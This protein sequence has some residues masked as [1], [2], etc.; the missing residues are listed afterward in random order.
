MEALA[1]EI[2]GVIAAFA[3][4]ARPVKEGGAEAVAFAG[5]GR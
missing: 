5:I 4:G 2:V 3:G 1:G